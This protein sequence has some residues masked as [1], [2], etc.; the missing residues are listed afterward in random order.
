MRQ[1]KWVAEKQEGSD[2]KT[3]MGWAG[4]KGKFEDKE[5]GDKGYD[6]KN[7]R[8]GFLWKRHYKIN[9]ERY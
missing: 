8:K 9:D 7:K 5:K 1:Q 2:K 4:L 3:W 6:E